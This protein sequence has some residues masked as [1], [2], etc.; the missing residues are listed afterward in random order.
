MSFRIENKYLINN[1]NHYD[2]YKFLKKNSAETLHPRREINSIYFDNVNLK[3]YYDSI[4]GLVPRKKIR[5]RF[6]PKKNTINH[7]DNLEIKINSIEGRY[8]IINKNIN[9]DKYF[10]H[11]YYDP[12]YGLCTPI[13]MVGYIREYYK[14]YDLR[15]TIDKSICY[16]KFKSKNFTL[17]SNSIIFE[18]KSDNIDKLNQVDEQVPFQKVRY[19]K[20]CNGIEKFNLV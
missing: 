9:K 5:V 18:I 10:N 1:E 16:K 13:L 14:M 7:E 20:F 17:Q 6:Y 12:D 3:S 2:F 4:E 8:K 11:G 19:S 15:V